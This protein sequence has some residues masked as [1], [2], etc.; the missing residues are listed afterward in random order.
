M[1]FNLLMFCWLIKAGLCNIHGPQL[2]GNTRPLTVLM[3]T[4]PCGISA[5]G[6]SRSPTAS[7]MFAFSPQEITLSLYSPVRGQNKKT[8]SCL[9]SNTKSKQA[10]LFFFFFIS[11]LVTEQGVTRDK[12]SAASGTKHLAAM[13]ETVN[14]TCCHT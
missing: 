1:T 14:K 10:F 12:C 9:Q 7:L 5:R 13:S 2:R 3:Q 6:H 4:R 8:L 11:S